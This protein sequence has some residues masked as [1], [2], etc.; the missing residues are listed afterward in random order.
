M[1]LE[2]CSVDYDDWKYYVDIAEELGY[3]IYIDTN[4]YKREVYCIDV[5]RYKAEGDLTYWRKPK[6]PCKSFGGGVTLF[7]FKDDSED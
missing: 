4:E 1:Q 5:L 7:K 2:L 6:L 3:N